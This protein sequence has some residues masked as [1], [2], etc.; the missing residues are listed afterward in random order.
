MDKDENEPFGCKHHRIKR[1]LTNDLSYF[2]ALNSKRL[3]RKL[4]LCVWVEICNRLLE[5]FRFAHIFEASES[6][7]TNEELKSCSNVSKY[8]ALFKISLSQIIL[9]EEK[10]IFRWDFDAA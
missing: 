6:T 4:H 8:I 2:L 10:Q 9:H 1:F 3:A 7:T 5:K